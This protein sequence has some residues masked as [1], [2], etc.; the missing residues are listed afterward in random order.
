LTRAGVLLLAVA[1]AAR[2][3]AAEPGAG[4]DEAAPAPAPAPGVPAPEVPSPGLAAPGAPAPAA[5]EIAR[6]AADVLRGPQTY[7]EATLRVARSRRA[8]PRELSFRSFD[9]R[10]GDRTLVRILSPGEHAGAAWLKLPPNLWAWVPAEGRTLRLPWAVLR[11]PWM[12]SGFTVDDLVHGSSELRDYEH[13]LLGEEERAGEHGDRRAWLLEYTPREGGLAAWGRIVAW[14]DEEHATPLRK[15]FYGG[16]GVLVRSLHLRDV[17][18]TGG[19]RYPHLWVVSRPEAPGAET[20]LRV[21]AVRFDADLDASIFGT[22][23]LE[24]SDAA[25]H[26][27]RAGGDP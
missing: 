8:R 25:L 2:A 7:L 15:D 11:E 22:R 13:R 3:G 19:R 12:E 26:S 18:E 1:L 5:D 6:R 14:I 10:E 9:D 20:Q 16:D 4:P 17:R 24:G 21:D 23:N 27:P